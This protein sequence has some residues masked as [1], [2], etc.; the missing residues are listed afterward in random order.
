[1]RI[2]HTADWHLGDRLGRIDRT[3]DLRRAVERVG[4]LCASE[5]IDVL[6]VAG[7]L[8]SELA[9][10]DALRET[11]EHW[12]T[13]FSIFLEG[14]GTILTLTGNHDNETFCQTLAKAMDLAAPVSKSPNE[15]V[16]GRLYLA[17]DP[18][19]L[20]LRDR[21][22]QNLVQFLLMPYPTPSRYLRDE[23]NRK[24]NSPEEKSRK[25]ESAFRQALRT[26]QQSP[27]FDRTLPVILGAHINVGGAVTGPSLFRMGQEDDV[28]F[29][30]GEL[31]EEFTY[32]ALGHIHKAQ[33]IGGRPHVR[34]SG[35]I[36]KMDLGEAN[37]FKEV[38]VFDV[39]ENGLVGD[40]RSIPL[41]STPVYNVDVLNP[42]IDLE[43]LR[44][45]HPEPV[46]DLVN[47]RIR[48][49]ASVDILEKVLKELEEIFPRWY[50]REWEEVS[51]LG[52][53]LNTNETGRPRGLE[54]TVRE[55]LERELQN[56]PDEDRNEVLRL[57][58]LLL[59]DKDKE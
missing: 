8:F 18:T 21:E 24:Y 57:A 22:N 55:Y 19:L 10:A 6:L 3:H 25:L 16:P 15:I 40:P 41:P 32:A 26:I 38:T 33:N 36:E 9:R 44:K 20:K 1:M 59:Q 29:E 31:T 5:K 53:S 13:V 42:S 12:K 30:A 17:T 11:I 2:L 52:P 56:H 28:V 7:D 43:E 37:D 45:K 48:Y 46:Q 4:D 39:N 58:D 23:E 27:K 49:N 54:E 14:G 51:V 35:S 50:A 34:Y 47:L